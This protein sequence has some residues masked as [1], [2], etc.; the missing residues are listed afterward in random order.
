MMPRL[1]PLVAV[2]LA[3]VGLA[4]LLP[5]GL[6]SGNLQWLTE[7]LLLIAM[8]QMWNL[9]AGYAGL[10]SLGHQVFVGLGAYTLFWAS[11]RVAIH[12]FW[13]LP[14]SALA[15]GLFAALV[16]PL[17]FRLRD[18][19]F[20]IGM[21]VLSEVVLLLVSKAE[22]LGGT[23]GLPLHSATLIDPARYPAQA[24]WLAAL[25]ALAAVLGLLW[26]MRHRVGLAFLSVRDNDLAAT[27][28]GV[29]VGYH[30][31][32]AFVISGGGCALA[33]AAYYLGNLYVQPAGAFDVQ[34]VVAMMFIVVIGGI[35]TIEGP[36]VGATL[37]IG[38]RELCTNGLALSGGG[39]LIGMGCVSIATMLW[40]PHGLWGLAA[41]YWGWR[42]LS[43]RR[44][45]PP[46]AAESIHPS[47]ARTA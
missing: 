30:R 34:W 12:P 37:Y 9:L 46:S 10:M 4:L 28:V 24:F 19:Y 43:V 2:T 20:A 38:L 33:G 27:S 6:D 22:W 35:G 16:A 29:D 44:H 18:A 11:A 13:L 41:Q 3:L 25:L 14:L 15:G 21:W 36:I 39:Y 45:P 1:S 47:K 8:A 5:Y 17:M 7:W 26:L 31:W 23:A 40:A 32:V 42:G